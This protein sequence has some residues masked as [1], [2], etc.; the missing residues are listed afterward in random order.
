MIVEKPW[1]WY[2][3]LFRSNSLVKKILFIKS[4]EEISFQYHKKRSE[5]W[6]FLDGSATVKLA[7]SEKET[8]VTFSYFPGSTLEIAPY[9]L[10]QVIAKE[11]DVIAYEVQTGECEECDIVRVGI[12]KYG[13]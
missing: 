8:P 5:F 3:D 6:R 13:R 11:N 4:G 1:G 2:L 12:D 9:T 10:H 7:M